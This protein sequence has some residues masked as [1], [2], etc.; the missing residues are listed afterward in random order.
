MAAR[1][2]RTAPDH[3]FEKIGARIGVSGEAIRRMALR[4]MSPPAR[5][6]RLHAKL[7]SASLLGDSEEIIA[8]GWIV[9]HDMLRLNTS[10]ENFVDF[11]STFF[12]SHLFLF[13]PH[14]I[15]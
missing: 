3:S 12:L 13:L 1:L 10:V 6:L 7:H 5:A 14:F 15:S 9:C 11:L 2:P 4:D 8:A